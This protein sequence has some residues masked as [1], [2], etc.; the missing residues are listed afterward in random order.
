MPYL[1]DILIREDIDIIHGH[2][3]FSPLVIE[4]ILH[5][6]TILCVYSL[7]Y[8]ADSLFS[9]PAKERHTQ[10]V[11]SAHSP[12]QVGDI[13][14]SASDQSSLCQAPTKQMSGDSR[15][16]SATDTKYSHRVVWSSE[17]RHRLKPISVVFT[18]P[19]LIGF[20]DLANVLTNAL[21]S[22]AS[23]DVE[24]AICVSHVARQYTLLRS[25]LPADRVHVIPN[26]VDADLF[27]PDTTKRP[28]D[29]GTGFTGSGQ[30]FVF[31]HTVG[32]F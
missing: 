9:P 25:R 2:S 19:S 1:Y 12:Q 13:S 20:V 31:L 3:A 29:K 26:A 27:T 18:D 28:K 7:F 17:Y 21:L 11:N 22:L 15:S 5:S 14:I 10:S 23:L 6:R 4:A 16:A 32:T 8:G 30:V 24:H